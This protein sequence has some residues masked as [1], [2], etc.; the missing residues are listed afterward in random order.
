MIIIRFYLKKRPK[1]LNKALK[2][3]NYIV[4][5]PGISLDDLKKK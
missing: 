4:L 2:N 1:N 3:V 5:S